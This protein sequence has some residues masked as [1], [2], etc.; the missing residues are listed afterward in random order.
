MFLQS[1]KNFAM[2]QAT[3]R[4]G[5]FIAAAHGLPGPHFKTRIRCVKHYVKGHM[6][7]I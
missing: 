2:E 3:D 6:Y 7:G 1:A 4:T 5:S